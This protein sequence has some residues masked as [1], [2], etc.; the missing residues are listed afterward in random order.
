MIYELYLQENNNW[1]ASIVIISLTF[2]VKEG[3]V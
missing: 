1:I 3:V 2:A